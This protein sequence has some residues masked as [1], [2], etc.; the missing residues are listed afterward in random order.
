MLQRIMVCG[1][2]LGDLAYST[3]GPNALAQGC[4]AEGMEGGSTKQHRFGVKLKR[5]EEKIAK[6][7]IFSKRK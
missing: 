2:L 3:E 5:N 1:T 4:C 7:K 6:K